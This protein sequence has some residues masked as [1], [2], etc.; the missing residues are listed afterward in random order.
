MLIFETYFLKL[1]KNIFAC[2]FYR[3]NIY[4]HKTYTLEIIYHFFTLQ[5]ER[6][7]S[8]QYRLIWP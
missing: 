7:G 6:A 2:P 5:L 8:L 3:Y 1:L 4:A